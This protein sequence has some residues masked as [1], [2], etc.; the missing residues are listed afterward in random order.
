MAITV[1]VGTEPDADLELE[2][3]PVRKE[4]S[5]PHATVEL[6]MRK[7][8]D[9][10]LIIY[11]H[12][13][14]DIVISPTNSKVTTFPKVNTDES[15]Y[16]SQMRLFDFLQEKGTILRDSVQGG[17]VYNA[18]EGKI[19]EAVDPGVDAIQVVI[20]TIS[21]FLDIERPYFARKEEYE[22]MQDDRLTQP[23]DEDSTRLG[24]VPQAD[25]KGGLYPGLYFQPFLSTYN[26]FY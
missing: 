9:G 25:Q 6:R 8:L 11:D 26:Y 15:S 18:V 10:D 20:L 5:K 22:K 3:P 7:T 12:E 1:R 21:E 17:S 4:K 19:M 23:T 24:E 14:L 16:H 2:T 13:D